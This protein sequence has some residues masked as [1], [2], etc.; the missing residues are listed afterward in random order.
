[1]NTFRTLFQI[2]IADFDISHS[3]KVFMLGSCFSTEIG[4]KMRNAN[5]DTTVNPGGIVFNPASMARNLEL[6]QS[7]K[8]WTPDRLIQRQEL[9]LSWD[10]QGHSHSMEKD[11]L[12]ERLKAELT[13]ANEKLKEATVLILTL[14]TAFTYYEQKTGMVVNNCHRFPQSDFQKKM[15]E[16]SACAQLLSDQISDLLAV[17]PDLKIIITISPV[18]HTRDG[19]IENQRSKASLILAVQ[20]LQLLFPQISYFPAYE[21]LL[22][23]LRDY[24]FYGQD[25]IHPNGVAVDYIWQHFRATYFNLQT[26]NLSDQIDEFHREFSH[27]PLQPDSKENQARLEILRSKIAQFES[28]TGIQ[29]NL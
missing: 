12:V 29:L 1:M 20:Q 10:H 8:K 26:Q 11:E 5:F 22:D 17:K 23:D 2:P 16:P 24:R 6:Y 14:G 25:M 21:L 4:E 9:W 28:E 3:D 15:L 7:P 27:R 18:R 13:L 19:M